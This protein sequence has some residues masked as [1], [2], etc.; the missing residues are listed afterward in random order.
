MILAIIATG[1][2]PAALVLFAVWTLGRGRVTRI[3]GLLLVATYA[4]YVVLVF[5][6]S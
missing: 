1:V 5:T 3:E 4:A 2:G 6:S